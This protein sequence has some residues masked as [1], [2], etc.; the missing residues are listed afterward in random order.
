[1]CFAARSKHAFR[2]GACDGVSDQSVPPVRLQR[3]TERNPEPAR[4][5][6]ADGERAVQLSVGRRASWAQSGEV[7][8]PSLMHPLPVSVS[9]GPCC[10]GQNHE[11]PGH[12]R[13]RPGGLWRVCVPSCGTIHRLWAVLSDTHEE[14]WKNVK[15]VCLFNRL[16]ECWSFIISCVSTFAAYTKVSLTLI[17]VWLLCLEGKDYSDCIGNCS[18]PTC[19]FYAPECQR[20]NEPLPSLINS[21]I[22]AVRNV[23]HSSTPSAKRSSCIHFFCLLLPFWR[24]I[25][26]LKSAADLQS[27]YDDTACGACESQGSAEFPLNPFHCV[28]VSW[29]LEKNWTQWPRPASPPP[30]PQ[31]FSLHIFVKYASTRKDF[32]SFG[33][34]WRQHFWWTL[35][36]HETLVTTGN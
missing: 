17:N 22:T 16:D 4:A 8:R 21:V 15:R 18:I 35:L 3:G 12:Q 2:P 10:C 6:R 32:H 11:G 19:S 24:H 30:P 9:E 14:D 25:F 23:S 28:I 7:E 31:G 34:W 26:P 13:R 29:K 33:L 20:A 36:L 27:P 5:P 1:M